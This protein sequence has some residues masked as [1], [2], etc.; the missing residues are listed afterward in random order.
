MP[1]NGDKMDRLLHVGIQ[2]NS[3]HTTTRKSRKQARIE[4]PKEMA[5]KLSKRKKRKEEKEASKLA[6]RKKMDEE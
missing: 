3:Q 6:E 4:T 5:A 1:I 2:A